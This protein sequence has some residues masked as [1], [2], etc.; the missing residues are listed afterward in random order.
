MRMTIDFVDEWV[1]VRGVASCCVGAPALVCARPPLDR[2][3][4]FPPRYQ[5]AAQSSSVPHWALPSLHSMQRSCV[6]VTVVPFSLDQM[7]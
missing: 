1:V 3:R 7:T 4:D 6:T 2:S 5:R